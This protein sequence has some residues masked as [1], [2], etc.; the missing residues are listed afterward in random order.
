MDTISRGNL[1][2]RAQRARLLVHLLHAWVLRWAT[3]VPVITARVH[4]LG[5]EQDRRDAAISA[6]S[7]VL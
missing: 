1:P 6:L 2:E 7:A 3:R 4:G 5:R